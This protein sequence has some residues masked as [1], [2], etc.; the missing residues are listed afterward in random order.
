[1]K[2]KL[3]SLVLAL[4]L[5]LCG[6]AAA[7]TDAGWTCPECGTENAGKFCTNCGAARPASLF[8]PN[9]GAEIDGTASYKFCPNC[10]TNLTD[11]DK[12]KGSAKPVSSLWGRTVTPELLE[13]PAEAYASE[14]SR[15]VGLSEDGTR[16]LITTPGGP[17]YVW[18]A[19]TG[20][21]I[22]LHFAPETE[23]AVLEKAVN[24]PNAAE[25]AI[26]A[27]REKI[28][29]LS[30]TE[31]VDYWLG[32]SSGRGLLGPCMLVRGDFVGTYDISHGDVLVVNMRDGAVCG[33]VRYGTEPILGE[34]ILYR[35]PPG[36][37]YWLDLSSGA[38][39]PE[40]SID[41]HAPELPFT[42][43][44]VMAISFL[45][46]GGVCALLRD[47]NTDPVNGEECAFVV[48]RADGA[49][50]AYPLGRVPFN[51]EPNVI[52]SIPGAD[53][54]VLFSSE[55]AR[56]T[57]PYLVSGGEVSLLTLGGSGF[58]RVPLQSVLGESDSII[59]PDNKSWIPIAAMADGETLLM[60]DQSGETTGLALLR[61]DTLEYQTVV[62]LEQADALGLNWFNDLGLLSGNGIDT[63]HSERS[64]FNNP[65]AYLHFRVE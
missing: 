11:T 46:G 4:A 59:A 29:A 28:S 9:C 22:P 19:E 50:E 1:M 7:E 33:W 25:A 47:S 3:L 34:R 63:F 65:R 52:L 37:L 30:Q 17:H 60:L 64:W 23:A 12:A 55:Y 27:L 2:R 18:V 61:P 45:D 39:S 8:C 14:E 54:F 5:L 13:L 16:A 32:M 41:F 53:S 31:L 49:R 35:R 10:G 20:E 24:L 58:V 36:E 40:T 44:D 38:I 56:L 15:L 21:Q 51:R 57:I 62:T 6:L 42:D 43:Y 26:A 48:L